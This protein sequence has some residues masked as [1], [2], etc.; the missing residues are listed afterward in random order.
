MLDDVPSF[1]THVVPVENG[2][3]GEKMERAAYLR[4]FRERDAIRVE[5]DA[6]SF[7]ELQQ[8]I[9]D[10][11]YENTNLPQTKWSV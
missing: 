6:A 7:G 10:L 5:A 11:P 2:V 9:M 4:T 1:I 3:V 8:R